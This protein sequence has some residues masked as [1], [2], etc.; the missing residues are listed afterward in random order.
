MYI[1][2]HNA[3][4][5]HIPKCGGNS[6]EFYFLREAGIKVDVQ[7]SNSVFNANKQFILGKHQGK[8]TAHYAVSELQTEPAYLNADYRFTIVRHPVQRFLSEH[9]WRNKHSMKC[10][11]DKLLTE[12]QTGNSYRLKSAWDYVSI[13][14]QNQMHNVFKLEEP[15]HTKATLSEKFNIEFEMPHENVSTKEKPI[16]T[17]KQLEII[18]TVWARDFEEFDYEIDQ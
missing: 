14:D 11:I 15:E 16:L 13:D 8:Q 1:A 18:R 9:A 7:N 12:L 17:Q 2:E 3:F 5:I 10:D 4:F 6:I